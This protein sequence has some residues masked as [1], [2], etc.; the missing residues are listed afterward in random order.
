MASTN[1][2]PTQN[3][4][5]GNGP[6][7]VLPAGATL[8]AKRYQI[9]R[10]L[11]SGRA[12]ESVLANDLVTGEKVVV[13][14]LRLS[15]DS[16]DELLRLEHQIEV[17]R[18]LKRPWFAPVL[19]T[20]RET[21]R[22]IVVR[23]HLPGVTL[24]ERVRRCS[25][26]VREMLVVGRLL[27]SALND[28]HAHGILHGD[29]RPTCVVVNE[30]TPLTSAVLTG[31][32]WDSGVSV[33][34]WTGEQSLEAALY[35]SP[36]RA[37]ALDC[38]VGVTSDFYSAGIVLFECLAGY[39]PFRGDTVGQVL[40]RQM[41]SRV[42]ELRSMGLDV[43][44]ALDEVLQRLLRKD[45]QDR[46][47]T[48][49]AVLVDL[50]SIEKSLRG[51]VSE[52]ALVVGLHDRRQTLTEPALVGR[53][54]E[55]AQFDGQM[56]QVLEGKPAMVFL[57][58][59]SGGGKTR[60]L[61]ELSVRCVQAG[62]RVLRGQ[63]SQ[64]VGTR[65][66]QHL[67]GI[68]EDLVDAALTDPS[69]ANA[70]QSQ[71][72]EHLDA[73]CAALPELATA[74]GWHTSSTLG[75]EA[76]GETR[77]IQALSAFLDALGAAEKP[78]LIALDDYQ[79]A[80]EMTTKLLSHWQWLQNSGRSQR[81]RVLLVVAFRSEEVLAHHPL[82]RIQPSLH[83]QLSSLAAEEVQSLLESM[84]GPLPK[85]AVDL[86]VRLSEGSPF[87]A[88]AL[89][90]GMV[91]SGVL[92]FQSDRWQLEPGALADLHSSDQAARF[93]SR[94]I[95]LLPHETIDLLTV[96]AVLGKEFNLPLAAELVGFSPPQA[97]AVLE[98]AT[99]RHL[100]W[101]R[102]EGTECAF[103]H[104]KIR[105]SLLARISPD[106][107][108]ELH[109]RIARRLEDGASTR[110]FDLAYHFDAADEPRRAL[111]YALAA[112]AQARS[113]HAL[114]VAEQQYR[115]ARRGE[116]FADAPTRFA[117]R[118]G[119]G[120][121]LMLRGC[122]PEAKEALEAA[123]TLA[124]GDF[125][126]AQIK[127]KLGELDFKQ[128]NMES[129]IDAFEDALRLLGERVPVRGPALIF[130]LLEEVAIQILHT[131]LPSVLVGRW[132]RKPTEAES[133]TMRLLS[134]LSYSYFYT[135]G[136]LQIFRLHFHSMNVAE[137]YLP[138]PERA[139][140][141]S[142]H[143]VVLTLLGWYRRGLAYVRKSY[144]I[145]RAQ[146]DLWGQGQSLSFWGCVFYAAAQFEN[147]IEK[148][149]E[150]VRLLRR[151]G[152]YW[153]VHIAQYQI[154]AAKY[155]L[156]DMQGAVEEAR[157]MHESGLEL[158]DGQASGISLDVWSLASGGRVSEEMLQRELSRDR[159]DAQGTVQVLVAEGVRLSA[160][161]RHAEAVDVL[162]RAVQESKRLGIM[163]AYT[164]PCLGWLATVARRFAE[165]LDSVTSD[166]RKQ[167]LRRAEWAARRAA[168]VA[169]RLPA[170]MPH[171]LRELALIRAMRGTTRGARR[172]LYRSLAVA[173]RQKARHEFAQ[174]LL[175]CGR[176]GLDLEW[177]HSERRTR[178]AET[179]LRA[180]T[181]RA[182][183]P[184]RGPLTDEA[185]V[186]LSLAD[187]FETVLDAG[188]QI[189][190]ALL[191]ASVYDQ[192]R[193]AALRLL[194]GEKCQLFE[195]V[196][197]GSNTQFVP[198]DVGADA[199]DKDYD[200][201]VLHRAL[202]KGQ[203]V[204]CVEDVSGDTSDRVAS[205]AKRSTLCVP[206]YVR[207]RAVACLHVTHE[208]VHGLFG[209]DEEH[210]ADF[211]ATI[212]GAALENAEGFA[213]LQRL[214]QTLER[215]VAERTAAAES[216][217]RE[218]E[219]T[220]YELRE[221]QKE[222]NVA[223]QAAESANQAKSRFLATMSHEIRTPMNGILGMTELVLNTP[224]TDQQRDYIRIA[225]DS[226]DALLTLLNDTLDLSKIEAGKMELECVPFSLHDLVTGAT[227]L[228]A[229]SAS[230]KGLELICRIA[231]DV[232]DRVLADP[233]RLRQVLVNLV[234]N[235]VKFTT[236]GDVFVNVW[237]ESAEGEQ[238]RVHFAVQDTG[239]GIPEDK[240][241]CVFE[242]FRQSDS[243]MTRRFGG[244]G[245]GLAI[246]A[247]LVAL[248]RGRISV[249]S[250]FGRGSTFRFVV[251]LRLEKP[252]AESTPPPTPAREQNVIVVSA[253]RHAQCTYAEV[254]TAAGMSV[255]V[256]DEMAQVPAI[257]ASLPSDGRPTSILV[258]VQ[259]RDPKA[260]EWAGCLAKH[261][262]A[263]LI[264]LVLL[265]PPGQIETSENARQIENA[266]CLV[267]PIR[268][269]DL[270]DTLEAETRARGTQQ[271]GPG[272][273]A[274]PRRTLRVL[275][276]DDSPVNQEVAA[277]LLE[278]QGHTVEAVDNGREA[279]DAF[280]RGGYDLILMDVE[281][282]EMDGLAA[283]AAI[284]DLEQDSQTQTPIIA[285][286]AHV[287]KGFQ[288]RCI[289]AGMDGYICK[290]IRPDELLSAIE[291]VGALA[292]GSPVCQT[293]HGA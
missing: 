206:L 143:A 61:G 152:D 64:Q 68:V 33:N 104:D 241:E 174:T 157:S 53:R 249:E 113:Q 112:A 234:G 233:N 226:A 8:V 170:G 178:A 189:A 27:F 256:L 264:S 227:R 52:S 289:E 62:M 231:P 245:L 163:S 230:Q 65:P 282:P 283:T 207:G 105:D 165:S 95:E 35:Q 126:R 168:R 278:L 45:P 242:A 98:E 31:L 132:N 273:K 158:G 236:E 291:S 55:T 218:L 271:G 260:I 81:C 267:K 44:R 21:D 122:Y 29:L 265:I 71:L 213:E 210:L 287:L 6:F 159:P 269:S 147:C 36:E 133:L 182:E 94:R 140:V 75:P 134:R 128:G 109:S 253:N 42:P 28:L 183:R 85:E 30:G 179:R 16:P 197:E 23:A 124:Q 196:Q 142:E 277:G 148:C 251:P 155:R 9:V 208:H 280:R 238:A 110:V 263:K 121:V 255:R 106:L 60:L 47:Q 195:V 246:S 247:Q 285:M 201:A 202:E 216:R 262:D 200:L 50:E 150:A 219:R 89:L 223:K 250:E 90:R 111:P 261:P 67:L 276:A 172:L 100:V 154:A 244:T 138:S 20:N 181:V 93:L 77:S 146:G 239:I 115:I 217:A 78:V 43:P 204:A 229:V 83:L 257:L 103:V 248:M 101:L 25:L 91:E 13:T 224:L 46:Y 279:V 130:G 268:A 259:S 186:T 237:L 288:E 286:T 212:A 37:G 114:E 82:R 17:L 290:P 293:E 5:Q 275:V 145:R 162:E 180:L 203:A 59:Q 51:E 175:V 205:A 84:A 73:V 193:D 272:E 166:R 151:T 221:A 211:I 125:E 18:G 38:E 70:L 2:A 258:D 270:V 3:G 243:S 191:P 131:L 10:I 40:I 15:G 32:A 194:R 235:A 199:H 167:L 11:E 118:Q 4:N 66:F 281:M 54:R 214:N 137:R 97:A 254:L 7:S 215:R 225:R 58:T 48:A 187:R 14:L 63:G 22:F 99:H 160:A 135:R 209:P 173:R 190:S 74:F 222:L 228:L 284:R 240:Q 108:R 88:S 80:D 252:Q 153:E 96:G 141:Y 185:S 76:F 161:G 274:Q 129:A 184:R 1:D 139:Q 26:D 176:L 188:R 24:R 12:S 232:P 149:R 87:M 192:L 164:A 69:I 72:G 169:R 34:K 120:E 123:A 156:G 49:E 102:T 136:R 292:T 266:K 92:Q 116:A 39:P 57:E 171:A 41:T 220:A 107:R 127:G 117:I 119:L 19:A 144:E 177:P 79:W 198:F 56:R 86:I